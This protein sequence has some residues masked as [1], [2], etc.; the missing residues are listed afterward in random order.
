MAGP[1]LAG[2][3]ARMSSHPIQVRKEQFQST[4]DRINV[5][6]LCQK[7]DLSVQLGEQRLERRREGRGLRKLMVSVWAG[8]H[9]N[10]RT[11]SRAA[12]EDPTSSS[13]WPTLRSISTTLPIFVVG[14]SG[15]LASGAAAAPE[16]TLSGG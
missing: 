16:S 14:L 4:R 2:A 9:D 7:R 12:L 5:T 8:T 3:L 1:R 15:P 6:G 13:S 11:S 10:F